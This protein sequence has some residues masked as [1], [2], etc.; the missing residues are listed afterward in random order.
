HRAHYHIAHGIRHQAREMMLGIF[1]FKRGRGRRGEKRFLRHPAT[2]AA[3]ELF[4]MWSEVSGLDA[5]LV[6]A[7]GELLA[8]RADEKPGKSQPP[9]DGRRQQPRRRQRR[10]RPSGQGRRS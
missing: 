5:E 1:R 8:D 6:K 10:R 3:F 2:P 9:R 4:R 7:W